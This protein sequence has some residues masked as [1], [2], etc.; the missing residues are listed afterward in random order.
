MTLSKLQR[1]NS[2]VRSITDRSGY[3][4]SLLILIFTILLIH[5]LWGV[6]SPQRGGFF[7]LIFSNSVNGYIHLLLAI[8]LAWLCIWLIRKKNIYTN[9]LITK[10]RNKINE[11][12]MQLNLEAN[13]KKYSFCGQSAEIVYDSDKI[14]EVDGIVHGVTLT[15]YARNLEGEYFMFM[16]DGE[17][18]NILKHMDHKIARI[19]L[20]EKYVP[21]QNNA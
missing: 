19:V 3:I 10:A 9:L 16:S 5:I 17:S 6:F 12:F 7:N 13:I 18:M 20:K 4:L 11:Q 21:P 8:V 15:R 1:F 2:I 14:V